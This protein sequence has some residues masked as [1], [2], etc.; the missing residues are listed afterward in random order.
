MYQI[1]IFELKPDLIIEIGTNRGGSSFY[2]ADLLD[3]VGHGE[4]HTLD[5]V[6]IRNDFMKNHNRIKFFLNGFENYDLANTKGFEKIMII[7]DGSHM[8]EDVKAALEK[9]KTIVSCGSYFII[10]DGILDH[11][12]WTDKYNGGP[13][14]A[15]KEFV[16][17][18]GIYEI[19]RKWCDFFGINA[20]FNTNGFLLRKK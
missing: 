12:G 11:L 9:F 7:D 6:D 20:T 10:E 19:D 2:L 3:L 13:N 17:E 14:R 1:L 8:Y 15:I 18:N 5:I 16:A 4:L